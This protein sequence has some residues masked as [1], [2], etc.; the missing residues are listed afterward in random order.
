MKNNILIF[1]GDCGFCNKTTIKLAE[2]DKKNEFIFVSNTSKM[3]LDL[4]KKHNLNHITDE[5]IILI[6]KGEIYFKSRAIITFLEKVN[7]YSIVTMLLK[8]IP[9]K[10]TDSLYT[11]ISKNRKNISIDNCSLPSYTLTKKIINK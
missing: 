9:R 5:T 4:L 11:L 3:G 1:D 2:I 10:I 6:L 7:Y 8:I